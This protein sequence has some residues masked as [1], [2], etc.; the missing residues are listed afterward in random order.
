MKVSYRQ[1]CI[2]VLLCQI[3]L[4]FLALPSLMYMESGSDSIF[5]SLVLMIVDGLYALLI[6][7]LAEL[8]GEKNIYE[9]MC[10]CLGKVVT[11][12]I[13]VVLML[14]FALVVANI[15]KGLEFFV[16]DNLYNEFNWYYYA[17]PIMAVVGFMIYK[18]INNIAR[19]G[20]MVFWLI[21]IGILYIALKSFASAEAESFLPLFK[22]GVTPLFESAFT[23]ASWFGSSTF[24]LMLFG[25][26]DFKHKKKGKMI[27][28]I[29][30]SIALVQF[31]YFVFYGIFQVTSPTHN[32]CLSDI[33]QFSSIHSSI[34][35]LSWLIVALWIV[36]QAV[37]LAIYSFCLSESIKYIFNLKGSTISVII[38]M[39]YIVALSVI[40]E[41]V[42]GSEQ[43]YL[44]PASSILA[45]TAQYI[46]P[47][48]L[49]VAGLIYWK[50]NK[51]KP[52]SEINSNKKA[53]QRAQKQKLKSASVQM[54]DRSII[55]TEEVNVLEQTEELNGENNKVRQRKS[56]LRGK[57][58]GKIKRGSASGG[59]YGTAN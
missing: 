21:L 42:I 54:E 47:L 33:S 22:E 14:K 58:K 56:N 23:H 7:K 44:H 4:K 1:T 2:L 28:Y 53:F 17:L 55:Q 19:V 9:F 20:E 25:K 49:A 18:G 12:I 10:A 29:I 43:I 51:N 6:L 13:M 30:L 35:E 46:I 11:K 57:T 59:K 41:Y 27:F 48:L 34:D 36:A 31:V 8:S 37:Q 3:A 32:F 52:T 50:R 16:V 15:S 24:L 45:I 40:G 39:F 26:I 5:V 38:V